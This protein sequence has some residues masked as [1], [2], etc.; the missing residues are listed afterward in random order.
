MPASKPFFLTTCTSFH[1]TYYA[2]RR[3]YA[4][5]EDWRYEEEGMLNNS[6]F[7]RGGG[8]DM[9]CFY[10]RMDDRM[11]LDYIPWL[12]AISVAEATKDKSE[13]ENGGRRRKRM[14][15]LDSFGIKLP[16]EYCGREVGERLTKLQVGGVTEFSEKVV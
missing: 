1:A 7:S 13:E 15:K 4:F 12:R 5:H 8:G 11:A 6:A 2:H 10:T 9:R 14:H 3:L 16:N